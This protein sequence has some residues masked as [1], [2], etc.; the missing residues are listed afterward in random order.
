MNALIIKQLPPPSLTN[1][2]RS[3]ENNLLV[4]GSKR[5]IFLGYFVVSCYGHVITDNL[6]KLWFLQTDYCKRLWNLGYEVV[7]ITQAN[8]TVPRYMEELFAFAGCDIKQ[9]RQITELETFDDVVVPDSCL[10]YKNGSLFYTQ[11]YVH[12]IDRIKLSVEK[13]FADVKAKPKIYYTRRRIK[14]KRTAEYNEQCVENEFR[15]AGYEI[16]APETLSVGQ[17]IY[18]TMKCSYFAASEGSV[19]HNILFCNENAQCVVL[20]KADYTNP[21]STMVDDVSGCKV[22]Y[23]K[24]HHSSCANR[25]EPWNGPFFF[26]ITP[27]LEAFFGY[28]IPHKPFFLHMSFWKM[29][30]ETNR[31]YRKCRKIFMKLCNLVRS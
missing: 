24:A 20:K 2:S 5:C 19:S 16:I 18:Y 29:R 12:I 8:E 17:C 1:F 13:H 31:I 6:K 3:F 9:C 28:K 7:Y 23:V 26:C 10:F 21:Y 11:E 14:S 27:Q 30:L 4:Y 25:K 22:E 15:K